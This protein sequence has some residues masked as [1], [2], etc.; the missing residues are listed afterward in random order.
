MFDL[1][2]K[3]HRCTWCET[4]ECTYF[5]S[6]IAVLQSESGKRKITE[7]QKMFLMKPFVLSSLYKSSSRNYQGEAELGITH[8]SE[9]FSKCASISWASYVQWMYVQYKWDVDL[10]I[11]HLQDLVSPSHSSHR[12]PRTALWT[13]L[14]L[15]QHPNVWSSTAFGLPQWKPLEETCRSHCCSHSTDLSLCK[16]ESITQTK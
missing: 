15:E 7:S 4:D 14:V 6:V 5:I 13:T 8:P 12:H 10:N 2:W 1:W 9:G 11:E 16:P 3:T